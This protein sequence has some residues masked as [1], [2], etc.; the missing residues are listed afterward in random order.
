MRRFSL[1][2]IGCG[3]LSALLLSG[4]GGS[5]APFVSPPSNP[6]PS[7]GTPA[8]APAS[9]GFTSVGQ[10]KT[11]SATEKGYSGA[12]TVVAGNNAVAT[13]SISGSTLTVTAKAAGS[14]TLGVKD[15]S[16]KS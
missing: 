4:C 15:A 2:H 1:P 12:W 13:A 6:P 9:A 10:T 8:L 7:S 16:G 14:T 5:A 11:F 3:L